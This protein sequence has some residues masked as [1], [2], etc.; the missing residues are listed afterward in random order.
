MWSLVL[1]RSCK[2]FWIIAQI[3]FRSSTSVIRSIRWSS[4]MTIFVVSNW[5]R[6]LLMQPF[7]FLGSLKFCSIELYVRA[8]LFFDTSHLLQ[9]K[10]IVWWPL[11]ASHVKP[12]VF[13]HST[14]E[15]RVVWV[16]LIESHKQ[17]QKLKIKNHSVKQVHVYKTISSPCN[18]HKRK[19]S[20]ALYFPW[21]QCGYLPKGHWFHW[22]QE[23]IRLSK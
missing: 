8:S 4:S 9:L 19:T 14:I 20:A 18:L 17:Q 22:W 5:R 1:L 16:S 6:G 2:S 7:L 3:R 23:Q 21:P 12:I 15:A 13:V 11:I 10:V